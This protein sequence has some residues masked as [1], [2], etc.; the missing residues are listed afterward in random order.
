MN[1]WKKTALLSALVATLLGSGQALAVDK[2]LIVGVGKYALSSANLTGIDL[3]VNMARD[4]ALYM[5]IRPENIHVL[6]DEQATL[7][8][9]REEMKTWL[10]QDVSSA[11]RVFFYY[12]GHGTQVPDKSG[13]EQDSLDEAMVLHDIDGKSYQGLYIDDDFGADLKRNPSRN[14]VVVVDACHS[15]TG[16]KSISFANG[17]SFNVSE[18]MPKFLNLFNVHRTTTKDLG[19]SG[20]ADGA[21]SGEDNY[22]AIAAAQDNQQSIATRKGSLFTVAFRDAFDSERG[23]AAPPTLRS[24]YLAT[25][26]KLKESGVKFQPNLS[27]N[28]EIAARSLGVASNSGEGS[29]GNGPLWQDISKLVD[30]L[31]ALSINAPAV[32]YNGDATEFV[33][34]IPSDGYLNIVMIG[35][36]D[37]GTVLFPNSYHADNRVQTG[38]LSFPT[39]QMPFRITAQPPY[40]KTLVAAFLTRERVN[41]QEEGFGNRDSSGKSVRPFAHVTRSGMKALTEGF[42]DL[43]VS[44]KEESVIWG[45]KREIEIKEK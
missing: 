18:G 3:D 10:A 41:M 45:G 5:G 1:N 40:G 38:H 12:S 34:D 8:H 16:T 22:L 36:K 44:A 6:L 35:P 4:M 33:V 28:Q 17:N 26:A 11:D 19:V 37:N 15:G 30:K 43:G 20:V 31:P 24:I 27:G 14:M 42:R 25:E 23:R 2:A 7:P 32:R 39:A 21:V 13:D 9:V 29:A